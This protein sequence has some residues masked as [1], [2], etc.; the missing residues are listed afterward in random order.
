MPWVR[1]VQTKTAGGQGSGT[2]LSPAAARE[3]IAEAAAAVTR[4]AIAR[5]EARCFELSGPVS[6]RLQ[7]Q[8]TAHADLF[9]QWPSFERI[10][11]VTLAFTAPSV[12]AAVRML[13]CCSAMSFMLK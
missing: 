2:T 5:P 8:T 4:S 6:C 13:N 12:Q 3:A 7:T 10:D 1:Y 11:G 9:C